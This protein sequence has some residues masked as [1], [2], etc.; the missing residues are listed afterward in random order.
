MSPESQQSQCRVNV[1]TR[2]VNFSLKSK[3]TKSERFLYCGWLSLLSYCFHRCRA[4]SFKF[5]SQAGPWRAKLH[6]SKVSFVND[7]KQVCL[8]PVKIS[9][10]ALRSDLSVVACQGRLLALF[11]W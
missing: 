9:V 8:L 7:P 10:S 6:Y 11:L 1:R 5:I 4:H 2:S 3:S